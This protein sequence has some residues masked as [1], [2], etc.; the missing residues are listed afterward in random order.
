MAS[1]LPFQQAAGS[2]ASV[3]PPAR[4]RQ[5]GELLVEGGAIDPG[6]LAEAL[7]H[8]AQ[9]DQRLGQILIANGK[10]SREAIATALAKQTDWRQ[11]DLPS[12]PADPALL[13][14]IDPYRCLALEALPWRQVGGTRVVVL[15]NPDQAEAAREVCGGSAARVV[16]ALADAAAIR[17]AI[18]DAFAG[19][20]GEDAR[21]RC[22]EAF[23]CRSWTR[24]PR[25][26]GWLAAVTLL[27]VATAAVPGAVF[28]AALLWALLMNA[29]TMLL[30]LAA[31]FVRTRRAKASL[32]DDTPRLADYMKLPQ[33]SLLVPLHDEAAVL[34][35]LVAA[36]AALDYPAALLDI[37]L[38]LEESDLATRAAAALAQLPP[39]VELIIVPP[40]PSL[41][42]K[43]RALNYALPF[44]RGD[45]IGIYDAED[46]PDPGQIRSVVQH[47]QSAPPEVACVQACLDFYNDRENW[48]ARF[49]TLDYA[50]WFRVTLHGAERLGMP[51]P[52]GG[53]SVF[54]RRG[55]LEAVGGWDADNVTEDADLGMRLARFGYRCEMIVSTTREEANCRLA[56]WIRQR[57]RWLKGYA[58]TWA[59]HMRRP[60]ELWRDL[61]PRG[62]LGFQLLFLGGL[63]AHLSQPLY[64]ALLL[65]ALSDHAIWRSFPDWLSTGIVVSM[66]FGWAVTVVTAMVGAIDSGR[67]WLAPWALLLQ[68]Y[69]LLGTVAAGKA[70]IEVVTRPSYWHKT[71]HGLSRRP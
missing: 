35:K 41:Q 3:A 40:D 11:I 24:A 16:F 23:S 67:P 44:C 29:L 34:P 43:P 68:V 15:A 30:R 64:L 62:F 48:L 28:A 42:T 10:V 57:S 52:L 17:R 31:L 45:I 55:A 9:Q 27:A 25:R 33:V 58:I 56:P 70:L 8:Q 2:A 6:A 21:D 22:P 66:L 46:E 54:I 26:R 12:A 69:A 51:I 13:R 14:G 19:R 60:R 53:T 7:M 1:I 61:G 38:V 65:G 20:M 59:T 49:F 39:T 47:L 32:P 4:R 50:T 71:A 5:I 63:T 37:K 18:S 36:L